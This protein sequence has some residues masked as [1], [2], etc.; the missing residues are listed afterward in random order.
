MKSGVGSDGGL[1]TQRCL[2][3]GCHKWG[4]QGRKEQQT[5]KFPCRK[6]T[7]AKDQGDTNEG[8][9]LPIGTQ[10]LM[11]LRMCK[12][13]KTCQT[14]VMGNDIST[15]TCTRLTRTHDPYGFC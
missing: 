3:V 5:T 12:P 1:E 7:T 6:K 4:E 9:W 15:L 2:G 13:V 10:R 11:T 8:R 14:W